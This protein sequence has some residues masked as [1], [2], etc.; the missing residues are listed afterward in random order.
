[1]FAATA[2]EP[3]FVEEGGHVI[4]TIV[5]GEDGTWWA[6]LSGRVPTTLGPTRQL[7]SLMRLVR[8]TWQELNDAS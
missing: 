8:R 6:T 5:R 4:A 1:M 3:V 7:G 2:T